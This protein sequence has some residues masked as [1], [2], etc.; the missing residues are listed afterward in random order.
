MGTSVD[1]KFEFKTSIYGNQ[2]KGV[3]DLTNFSHTLWAGWL[4]SSLYI[5]LPIL[6]VQL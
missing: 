5:Y 2:L 1:L 3:H 6:S 4:I